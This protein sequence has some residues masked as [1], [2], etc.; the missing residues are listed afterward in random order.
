MALRNALTLRRPWSGRLQGRAA[1]IQQRGFALVT[2]LWTAMIL[3][4]IVQSVLATSRTGAEKRLERTDPLR[5]GSCSPP[6]MQRGRKVQAGVQMCF[7]L[8]AVLD[9]R[10][11][12]AR[13][14]VQSI[15]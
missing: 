4:L 8:D 6:E 3:A 11:E 2:V 5:E 10:S 1:L 7:V 9:S 12:V 15:Q 14:G 13:L